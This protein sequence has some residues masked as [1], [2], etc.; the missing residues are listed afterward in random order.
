MPSAAKHPN[1]ISTAL[2][3][4]PAPADEKWKQQVRLACVQAVS[5]RAA[6]SNEVYNAER[7]ILA[8]NRLTDFVL[9]GVKTD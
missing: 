1:P 6:A 7:T 3:A 5:A 9:N 8:A 2:A 4:V